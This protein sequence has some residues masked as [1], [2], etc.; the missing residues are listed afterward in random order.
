M[1]M[2]EGKKVGWGGD[3]T[4]LR[5]NRSRH[6]FQ[7]FRN[8]SDSPYSRS[9]Q[10]NSKHSDTLIEASLFSEA[11]KFDHLPGRAYVLVL[12]MECIISQWNGLKQLTLRR[13]CAMMSIN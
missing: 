3:N 9:F 13:E 10:L 12:D 5:L 6:G 1:R 2:L 7:C 4:F 11:A 8:M